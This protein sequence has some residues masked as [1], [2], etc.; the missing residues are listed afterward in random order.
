ML[1]YIG[2]EANCSEEVRDKTKIGKDIRC[3]VFYTLSARLTRAVI[4]SY[5][6]RIRYKDYIVDDN[7]VIKL[8]IAYMK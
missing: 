7:Q 4:P 5:N 2:V 8:A 3:K 1:A 6:R